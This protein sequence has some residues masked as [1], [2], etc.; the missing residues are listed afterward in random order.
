MTAMTDAVL[1]GLIERLA[2]ATGADRKLD[3]DIAFAVNGNWE[4][5]HFTRDVG[6]ALAL[7]DPSLYWLI[8][9]GKV[10][11][12][13]PLY[14]CQIYQSKTIARY[15][16]AEAEHDCLAICI[17]IAALKARGETP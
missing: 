2:K 10:K 9:K 14:G 16:R 17:C 8:G 3:H 7:I 15:L 13:E 11:P 4:G 1:S 6:P 12:D 5:E